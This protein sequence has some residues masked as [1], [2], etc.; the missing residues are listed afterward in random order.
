MT[1]EEFLTKSNALYLEAFAASEL[2]PGV[3]RL[4]RH[5]TAHRV[6]IGKLKNPRN[7]YYLNLSQ[8]LV[9]ALRMIYTH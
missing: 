7:R 6:P 1:D 8:G 2:L 4:I 9:P 3:E 5:L